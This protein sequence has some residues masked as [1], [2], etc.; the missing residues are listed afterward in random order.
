MR[1][2]FHIEVGIDVPSYV[3]GGEIL[4]KITQNLE[5][6]IG[7]KGSYDVR[8]FQARHT[9]ISKYPEDQAMMATPDFEAHNRIN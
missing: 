9:P 6:T 7:P 1:I 3:Q 4:D 8:D 2:V 5:A